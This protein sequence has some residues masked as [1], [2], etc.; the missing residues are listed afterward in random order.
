[1]DISRSAP[2]S[3]PASSEPH[4]FYHEGVAMPR[5]E[6]CDLLDKI[7]QK[8]DEVSVSRQ[9]CHKGAHNSLPAQLAHHM[10]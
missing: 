7:T 6:L 10:A 4:V 1:M 9:K 3:T 2:L 8:N 5:D